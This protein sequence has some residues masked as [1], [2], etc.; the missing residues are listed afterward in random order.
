MEDLPQQPSGSLDCG[1]YMITYAECLTFGGGVPKVDF[2]P[3]L[4]RTRYAAMLW[5]YGKRKEEEKAQSDDEAPSRP[6]REIQITEIT[7]VTDICLLF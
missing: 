6:R 5:H 2:D 7:E 3:D 1:L 4:P